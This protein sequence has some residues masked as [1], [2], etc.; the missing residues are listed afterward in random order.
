MATRGGHRARRSTNTRGMPAGN[1]PGAIADG[2]GA[3]ATA[4]AAQRGK[5]D[6]LKILYWQAPTILNPHLSTG[7]KDFDAARLVLEPLAS[8]GPDGKPLANGLAAEIPTIANGGIKADLTEVTWKLRTR[9]EVVG[10]NSVHAR[11]TSRSRSRS[12]RTRRP[13]RRRTARPPA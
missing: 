1:G 4:A 10:R 6:D 9:R 8:W 13:R 7:T 3:S 2:R 5:G 12:P 11:M